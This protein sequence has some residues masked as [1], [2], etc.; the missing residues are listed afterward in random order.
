MVQMASQEILLLWKKTIQKQNLM[1]VLKSEME[2]SSSLYA[3]S[4]FFFSLTTYFC[5]K[6][7]TSFFLVY[8]VE[9]SNAFQIQ[10]ITWTVYLCSK[11]EEDQSFT[12]FILFADCSL[13]N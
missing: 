1:H 11:A 3:S 7:I 10:E 13:F 8:C 2:G 5:E 12:D 4:S 9:H 6:K